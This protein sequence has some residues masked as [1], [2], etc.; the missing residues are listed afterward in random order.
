M[1][2]VFKDIKGFEGKYQVS[3]LGRIRSL[4]YRMTGK[5]HIMK[6]GSDGEYDTV[7]FYVNGHRH[8]RKVHRVVAEAFIPNPDNLPQVNHLN[9]VKTDN[10]AE[11]LEW[12]D[13]K[14]N[15]NY[16]TRN[17]RIS[18]HNRWHK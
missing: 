4:N 16:G 10:R 13:N 18:L 12:C 15:S 5:H 9:E 1:K 6:F 17:K 3:N 2:E 7:V 11:N 8:M 14:Y